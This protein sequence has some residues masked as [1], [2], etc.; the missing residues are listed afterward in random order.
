VSSDGRPLSASFRTSSRP[1][2]LSFGPR[3]IAVRDFEMNGASSLE[4][5]VILG[6]GRAQVW[7]SR[8]WCVVLAQFEWLEQADFELGEQQCSASLEGA[9]AGVVQDAQQHKGDQRDIDLDAHSVFT[10]S[11][12]AADL[13]VLLEPLEQQLDLPSLFVELC[14]LEG[15]SLQVV[16]KQIEGLVVIG[17]DDHNLAQADLRACAV[18]PCAFGDSGRPG[19]MG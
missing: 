15:R 9:R 19:Q 2:K 1:A 17:A 5:E 13:E 18:K 7:G 10:A 14:D 11:E 3:L 12:K 8:R 16:G 6:M 4:G